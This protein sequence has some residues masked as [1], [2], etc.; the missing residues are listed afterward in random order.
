MDSATFNKNS[1]AVNQA[2]SDL[3]EIYISELS[4]RFF[5]TYCSANISSELRN[6]IEFCAPILW[7]LLSKEDRR[8]VGQ[9]FDK[10]LVSG[11][12]SKI[13]KAHNNSYY[14]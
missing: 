4:S 10:Y 6:N 11:N 3:P 8:K 2:F 9:Q 12:N 1:L 13:E 5:G 7:A 14:W